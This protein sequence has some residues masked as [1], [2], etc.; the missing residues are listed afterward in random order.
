M[1]KEVRGCLAK[2]ANGRATDR[3][4]DDVSAVLAVEAFIFFEIKVIVSRTLF[5]M[6]VELLDEC[7]KFAAR[8]AAWAHARARTQNINKDLEVDLRWGDRDVL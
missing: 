4:R 3:G 5:E 7:V 8:Q 2:R 6:E 1:Q